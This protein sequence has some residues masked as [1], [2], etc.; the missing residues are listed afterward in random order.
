MKPN[1]CPHLASIWCCGSPTPRHCDRHGIKPGA[2]IGAESVS[3]FRQLITP[4][5]LLSAGSNAGRCSRQP[6]WPPNT[7]STTRDISSSNTCGDKRRI[8]HFPAALDL[9]CMRAYVCPCAYSR[10]FA[11]QKFT[12]GSLLATSTSTARSNL[13]IHECVCVCVCVCVL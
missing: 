6:R 3:K 7:V 1:V 9:V 11:C 5:H 2:I 8:K 13:S 10:L 12:N 4:D